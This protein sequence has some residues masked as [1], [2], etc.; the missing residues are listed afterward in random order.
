MI[1]KF[2]TTV[3]VA[4]AAGFAACGG[5]EQEGSPAGEPAPNQLATQEQRLRCE[6]CDPGTGTGTGGGTTSGAHFYEGLNAQNPKLGYRGTTTTQFYDLTSGGG[7]IFAND[8]ARSMLLKGVKAGVKILLCDCPHPSCTD[9]DMLFVWVKQDQGTR[10]DIVSGFE[11]NFDT[12][13]VQ[14]FFYPAIGGQQPGL[15][16]KVSAIWI[17]APGEGPAAAT[18]SAPSRDILK[19]YCAL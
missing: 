13:F 7:D 2:R 15:T 4:F 19:G 6:T 18:W 1:T 16:G 3:V 11:A 10:S 9:D 12:G 17:W 8:A 14:G 5:S